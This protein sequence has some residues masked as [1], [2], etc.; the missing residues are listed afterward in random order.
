MIA[1]LDKRLSRLRASKSLFNA[2][3]YIRARVRVPAQWRR[4]PKVAKGA[5]LSLFRMHFAVRLSNCSRPPQLLKSYCRAFFIPPSPT[6]RISKPSNRL[7]L[8]VLSTPPIA[9]STTAA[10]VDKPEKDVTMDVD[11]SASTEP[12]VQATIEEPTKSTD[13]GNFRSISTS[14]R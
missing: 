1:H 4:K 3:Y 7:H 6:Q 9:M 13:Q 12:T 8:S 2:L 10:P 14:T 11:A 5:R